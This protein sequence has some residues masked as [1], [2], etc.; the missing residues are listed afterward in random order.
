MPNF[1]NYFEGVI[2]HEHVSDVIQKRDYNNEYTSLFQ[3][4]VAVLLHLLIQ[5][6]ISYVSLYFKVLPYNTYEYL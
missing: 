4:N 5:L 1:V 2:C 6:V 3:H